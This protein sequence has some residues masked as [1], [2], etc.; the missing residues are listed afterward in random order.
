MGVEID[1]S[2]REDLRDNSC[3]GVGPIKLVKPQFDFS[4]SQAVQA[5]RK[6]DANNPSQL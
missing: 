6:M 1:A 3:F 4:G 5:L 2:H